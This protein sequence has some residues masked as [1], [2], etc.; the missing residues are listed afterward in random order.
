MKNRSEKIYR[1]SQDC[2]PWKQ[3]HSERKNNREREESRTSLK[4]KIVIWQQQQ[5]R[6]SKP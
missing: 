4:H 3:K 6:R 2:F 1:H 5:Q